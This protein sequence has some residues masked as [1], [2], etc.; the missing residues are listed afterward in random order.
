MDERIRVCSS[1]L[2]KSRPIYTEHSDGKGG[3]DM[4]KSLL[5]VILLAGVLSPAWVRAQGDAKQDV[6]DAAE[7]TE[8]AAKNTGHKVKKTVKKGTRKAAR[9]VKQGAEKVD[10]KTE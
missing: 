7:S 10:Q 6:K 5:V 1:S 4:K 2:P 3:H 8:H 9:K